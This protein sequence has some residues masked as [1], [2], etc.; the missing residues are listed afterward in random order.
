MNL[1]GNSSWGQFLTRE[2]AIRP[3]LSAE[4]LAGLEKLDPQAPWLAI[5]LRPLRV[6]APGRSSPSTSSWVDG[7]S[8]GPPGRC[9]GRPHRQPL[10]GLG[11]I[12]DPDGGDASLSA[13]QGRRQGAWPAPVGRRRRRID[14]KSVV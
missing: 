7:V 11:H 9:D 8:L 3:A 5:P 2:R 13:R 6:S 1:T 10:G 14:R 12:M 4:F